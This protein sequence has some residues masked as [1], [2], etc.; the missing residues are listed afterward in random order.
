MFGNF[1]GISNNRYKRLDMTD[2]NAILDY[3]PTT[4]P[5][6]WRAIAAPS[7]PGA[8]PSLPSFPTP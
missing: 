3:A 8:A 2:T 4:T 6:R 5:L 7:K 1:H